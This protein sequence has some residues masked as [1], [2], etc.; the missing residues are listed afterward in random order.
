M[1][2]R[3]NRPGYRPGKKAFGKK[4]FL[5]IFFVCL[6]RTLKPVRTS[7]WSALDSAQNFAVLG[8]QTLG[9]QPLALSLEAP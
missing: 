4:V 8:T 2:N 6:W 9:L 3:G 5:L 1:A 7:T